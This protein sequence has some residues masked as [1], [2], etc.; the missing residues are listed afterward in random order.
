M[1]NQEQVSQE[2]RPL[3]NGDAALAQAIAGEKVKDSETEE[4]KKTLRLI[5]LK[6][7]I[8]AANLPEGEEK[9][10]LI[11]HIKENYGNHT[12]DEIKLAFDMGIQ[13]TLDVKMDTFEN[14]SCL[15]FSSVMNAYRSWARKEVKH[16][17]DTFW[18]TV[19][20]ET[21]KSDAKENLSDKTMQDWLDETAKGV[22]EKNIKIHFLPVMLADWLIGKGID[23]QVENQDV[24]AANYIY[25][26]LEEK[27]KDTREDAREFSQYAE[28]YD[29]GEF[30]GKWVAQ[31]Q[32]LMKQMALKNYIDKIYH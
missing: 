22:K 24:R 23:M 28:M 30:S 14:F 29:K 11:D 4:L 32:R 26:L 16:V 18:K 8:R 13:G 6:V 19:E 20:K 1:V 7:G 31:I 17:E 12:I 10:V 25:E 9:Q 3:K 15:Y 5:M 2:L 27:G 21:A